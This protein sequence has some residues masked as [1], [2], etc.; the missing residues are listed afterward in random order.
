[1][2]FPYAPGI[3]APSGRYYKTAH[4]FAA[5]RRRP[6]RVLLLAWVALLLVMALGTDFVMPHDPFRQSLGDKLKPPVWVSGATPEHILG[7]DSLGRDV[8]SRIILGARVSLALG[9]ASILLG[10]AIGTVAGLVSAYAG[11]FVDNCLMGL[12]NAALAFPIILVGLILAVILGPTML[13]VVLSIALVVW[14]RYARLVR[15]QVLSVKEQDFVQAARVTG[16]SPVRI[17]VM[18]IFPN[19]FDSIVVLA[20]LQFGWAII[21]EASLSFLG[22]GVPPPIASWGKMVADGKDYLLLDVWLAALPG[23]F[24]AATVL[25]FSFLGDVLRDVLDP[26]LR[27]I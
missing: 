13:G 6:W 16:C 10:T 2:T 15:G 17:L 9:A 19:V 8:L 26:R 27:S 11:G 22:V 25:T 18:H 24:I 5:A 1:M 14:A 23:L 4:L 3:A 12:A 20:T 21:T 7:T